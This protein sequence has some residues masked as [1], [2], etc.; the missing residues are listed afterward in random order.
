[1]IGYCQS[2]ALLHD[3][4]TFIYIYTLPR[5]LAAELL[6]VQRVP[7][8]L[9]QAIGLNAADARRAVAALV[10]HCRTAVVVIHRPALSLGD[11]NLRLGNHVLF[12]LVF[13]VYH[14]EFSLFLA[15]HGRQAVYQCLH[16]VA[17]DLVVVTAQF[18]QLGILRHVERGQLVLAAVQ[19]FQLHEELD[20]LEVPDRPV[21]DIDLGHGGD[22]P[23]VQV[24]VVV[25]VVIVLHEFSEVREGEVPRVDDDSS[26][27]PCRRRYREEGEDECKNFLCHNV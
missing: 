23:L 20:A 12:V 7:S 18:C 15:F 1:M 21:K 27:R 13:R 16:L 11:G 25:F 17:L 10:F 8:C 4:P 2:L 9:V 26:L 24:V 19:F 22:F 5:R 14:V 3:L 6:A